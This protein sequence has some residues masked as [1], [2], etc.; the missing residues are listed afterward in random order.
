[1]SLFNFDPPTTTC[2]HGRP[3]ADCFFCKTVTPPFVHHSET[4]LK[5]AVAVKPASRALRE[6]VYTTIKD[7]TSGM[8]DEEIANTTGLNPST[9]RPRRV[10]LHNAG[11][12]KSV[13]T[14]KTAS[15]R[16]AAVWVVT[17]DAP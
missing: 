6:I 9:A 7:S 8:T 10:E 15:N 4:S 17:E 16:N 1:M 11:R 5:A 2:N 14:R 3:P 12:I 13:G